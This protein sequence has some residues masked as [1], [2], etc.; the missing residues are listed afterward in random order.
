MANNHKYTDQV[1]KELMESSKIKEE[2]A[3]TH[4]EQVVSI[5]KTISESFNAGNKLLIC[6]NG[7]SAADS[8]HMAAE[9]VNTFNFQRDPLPAIA[10][11]VDTSVITSIANDSNYDSIFAR[12]IAA[13][14][15]K[16]DVLIVFSTSGNSITIVR[17]IEE[18]RTQG[19]MTIGFTGK[20]GGKIKGMLDYALCVP[21]VHTA[22]IQEAHVALYHIICGMVEQMMFPHLGE[23]D[24]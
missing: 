10:L 6:G 11:S 16:G 12:Q 24:V 9:F 13:L 14:G 22:R 18:A 17:A 1:R 21:S 2:M 3:Q 23:D 15:R 4:A 7:G 5:A 8:Q 19:M 20:N